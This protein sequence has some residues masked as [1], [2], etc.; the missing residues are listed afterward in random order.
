MKGFNPSEQ[1]NLLETQCQKLS[2]DIYRAY[3]LY[4]QVLRKQLKEEIKKVIFSLISSTLQLN[5]HTELVDSARSKLFQ[6]RI[7]KLLQKVT[8]LLTIEYLIDLSREIQEERDIKI[9]EA[10]NQALGE[11]GSA[12]SR[13]ISGE[14]QDKD[15]NS[16]DLKL[17]LPLE[18][19]DEVN[20]WIDK[21]LSL[22][23]QCVE[24]VSDSSDIDVANQNFDDIHLADESLE[25]NSQV[26]VNDLG[27]SNNELN[28]L[29]SLFMLAGDRFDKD[30]KKPNENDQE[31][32][33]V[34]PVK[35][36]ISN[37]E[38]GIIPLKPIEMSR[39]IED[40]EEALERRLR[41]LSYSINLELLRAGFINSLVPVTLLE[42]VLLG[43]ISTQ[44]SVSNLVQFRIPVGT[45]SL[46]EFMEILCVLVRSSDIEFDNPVLRNCR[47]RIRKHRQLL[48]RM[49]RQER[50]WQGRYI[51]SELK[52]NWWQNSSESQ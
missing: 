50:H 5:S 26:E 43:Q 29:K 41:D 25:T 22:E 9:N 20:D 32:L 12:L 35:S 19:P 39:W 11:I 15:F 2:P 21:N 6:E 48:E 40:I 42:A 38:C 10:K 27:N 31:S 36:N 23:M 17:S 18:D 44:C 24:D 46:N 8:P 16:L 4:L 51:S 28:I 30:G 3:A 37:H 49:V 47:L 45:G 34:E 33:F 1:L 7:D 13:N 14:N 52:R